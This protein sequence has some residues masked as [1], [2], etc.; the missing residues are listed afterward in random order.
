M[1]V[2]GMAGCVRNVVAVVVNSVA[3]E[4]TATSINEAVT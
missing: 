1:G 3:E 2:E 4:N